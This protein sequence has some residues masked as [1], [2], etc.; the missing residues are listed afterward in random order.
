MYK[1]HQCQH[2]SLLG[3]DHCKKNTK[4]KQCRSFVHH[5][6]VQHCIYNHN[7]QLEFTLMHTLI[8]N[9]P[10][11][12][13]SGWMVQKVHTCTMPPQIAA[14]RKL[15]SHWSIYNA[16][17][18]GLTRLTSLKLGNVDRE[19]CPG[20]KADWTDRIDLFEARECRQRDVYWDKSR[21]DWL[22]WPVWS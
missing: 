5:R 14:A 20:L 11:S 16:R 21:L 18:T 10:F 8:N 17:K 7:K 12:A 6:N 15:T 2:M 13:S 1:H 3:N 9:G 19:V 4:I 22:D